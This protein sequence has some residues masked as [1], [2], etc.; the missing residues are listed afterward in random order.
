MVAGRAT[1]PLTARERHRR[2]R[3]FYTVA[4]PVVLPERRRSAV[5]I[6]RFR[7]VALYTAQRSCLI[8][9][10]GRLSWHAAGPEPAARYD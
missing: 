10:S 5:A 7:L 8:R 6:H 1:R 4:L 3:Q 2:Y 9:S